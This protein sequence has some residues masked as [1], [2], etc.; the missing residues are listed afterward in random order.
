MPPA[1]ATIPKRVKLKPADPFE[2]IRWLARSQS[3]PRKAV[4]ELVQNS[5]DAG[6]AHVRVVRRRLRK[7]VALEIHDDGEGVIPELA[8]DKALHYLATHIGHSR[9]RGLSAQQRAEQVVAGQYGVGL[10]GFWAIGKDLEL[11]TRV[12]GSQLMA[13]CLTEDSPHAKIKRLPLRT[14]AAATYTKVVITQVHPSASRALSG[15]R[16][17]DYLAAELRGQL[18]QRQV[19]LVV[20]DRLARG[21]A[22]KTFTVEPRAFVGEQLAIPAYVQVPGYPAAHIQL[23]FADGGEPPRIQVACAGTLVADDIA[24]LA[25]LGLNNAPWIGRGLTGIIDFAAFSVPPGT[26]RGVMPNHA[27]GAFAAALDDFSDLVS[28]ELERRDRETSAAKDR[29][30][31]RDLRRALRGFHR[32]LPQYDFPTVPAVEGHVSAPPRERH[33]TGPVTT[34][35]KSPRPSA[36]GPLASV[37]LRPKTL[38]VH[39]GAERRIRANPKDTAGCTLSDGITFAWTLTSPLPDP[40]SLAGSGRCVAVVAAPGVPEGTRATLQLDAVAKGIHAYAS[41]DVIVVAAK[42][43]A[44]RFGI[45]DPE[46]LREPTADWRSRMLGTT[47]QVNEAHADYLSVRGDAKA[48]MRYLL[49]L[50]AKEMVQYAYGRPGDDALLEHMV[51]ILAHAEAN[52]RGRS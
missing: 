23:Y 29:Q 38:E 34:E 10:L 3:D 33:T 2:L 1:S 44:D 40:L 27:A 17:A 6:A 25:A 18:M 39:A 5:F 45:V 28:A 21:G 46:L 22:D 42:D 11:R 49:A 15:R 36:A 19:E 8:R 31:M 35:P 13:L 50:L 48:R 7:A 43:D 47:W 16:L 24:E 20:E 12:A 14:D 52:L 30:I 37:S 26:R 9:K 32:R 41:A 4:A 51:E